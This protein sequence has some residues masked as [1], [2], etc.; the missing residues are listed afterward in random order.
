[1]AFFGHG[2]GFALLD[3]AEDRQQIVAGDAF[4]GALSQGGQ[5]VFFE[6]PEDLR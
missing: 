3:G 1:M 2:E 5:D 6:D 4:D